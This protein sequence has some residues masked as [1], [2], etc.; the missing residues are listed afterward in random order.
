[1]SG[2]EW[3]ELIGLI[4]TFLMGVLAFWRAYSGE[5]RSAKK[6][7]LTAVRET[8]LAQQETISKQQDT[9]EG[10]NSRIQDALCYAEDLTIYA[11]YLQAELTRANKPYLTFE[12]WRAE[13]HAQQAKEMVAKAVDRRFAG[14][15]E[16]T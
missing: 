14:K 16:S 5:K 7:E 3:I 2:R 1:M 10:L 15:G 9:I 4:T 12:Q 8:V 11:A 6:D 13:R